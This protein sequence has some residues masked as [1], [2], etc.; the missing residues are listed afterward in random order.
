MSRACATTLR[1]PA[2]SP[3]R[4]TNIAVIGAGTRSEFRE[5]DQMCCAWVAEALGNFGYEPRDQA[6]REIIERWRGAAVDAWV[7]GKSAAY[8]R[9]SGQ[10]ADLRFVLDHVDDLDALFVLRNGEV[11]MESTLGCERNA[12][13]ERADAV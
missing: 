10:F 7:G 11:V 5:E 4:F 9:R 6:T 3:A 1:L 12:T 8:L 13:R 2:G